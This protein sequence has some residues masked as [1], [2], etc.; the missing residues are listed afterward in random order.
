M[1]TFFLSKD[2]RERRDLG[3]PARVV[4]VFCRRHQGAHVEIQITLEIAQLDDT[5]RMLRQEA[6]DPR[7]PVDGADVLERR[8]RFALERRELWRN[9]SQRRA[10][11]AS[12]VGGT[13]GQEP[14]PDKGPKDAGLL[15]RNL[16]GAVQKHELVDL[17]RPP[18]CDAC[19]IWLG[20]AA[21]RSG[22][23]LQM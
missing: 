5:L 16:F 6:L 13:P 3:H 14:E 18:V 2:E 15:G 1:Q 12:G 17:V 7:G 23:G 20:S 4:G 8:S 22:G 19:H 21:G 9:V 10:A 11:P